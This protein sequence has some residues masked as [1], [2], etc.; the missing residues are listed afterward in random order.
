MESLPDGMFPSLPRLRWLDARGNVLRVLPATVARHRCLE[1]LLLQ[2]NRLRE[3][4]PE[5]GLVPGLRGLQL[6]G[7]PL[8][9]PP[10][11]VV[12]RGVRAVLSFLREQWALL[13]SPP[14]PAR[15]V[16]ELVCTSARRGGACSGAGGARPRRGATARA[17]RPVRAPRPEARSAEP[18]SIAVRGRRCSGEPAAPGT[19]PALTRGRESP[20]L[21]TDEDFRQLNE[22]RSVQE[23]IFHLW[24]SQSSEFVDS[25]KMQ[26]RIQE[27][28]LKQACVSR[29]KE[30]LRVVPP[31]DTDPDYSRML[32]RAESRDPRA[33]LKKSVASDA[34]NPRRSLDEEVEE[35]LSQL[36]QPARAAGQL[37]PR[38]QQRAL[39]SEIHELTELQRRLQALKVR[40]DSALRPTTAAR[41][42]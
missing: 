20:E 15:P 4:P 23:K 8:R 21:R 37:S 36:R 34:G 33:R 39:H 27:T 31:Y 6:A 13:G 30:M 5:L 29:L 3:L 26:L 11:E 32:C 9:S 14:P 2:G 28:H 10:A 19:T 35:M 17:R 22:F 12:G 7:N 41:K 25:D 42:K 18:P 38:S 24:P 16:Q 1:V 40:N